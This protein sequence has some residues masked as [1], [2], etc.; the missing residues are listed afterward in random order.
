M[1]ILAG[2]V[3]YN[4]D[5]ARLK[6]NLDAVLEQCKN[7]VIFDNGSKNNADVKKIIDKYN[8]RIDLIEKKDNLGIAEALKSIMQY[9]IDNSYSWVLTLDQDSVIMPN[10]VDKYLE[11]V[12]LD[13]VG[14]LTCNIIDRNF[15]INENRNSESQDVDF[16]ITSGCFMSVDA[17]KKTCGYDSAMFIDKVDFDICFSLRD[18]GFRILKVNFDGLLHEVGHG[19]EIRFLGIKKTV[20][21]HPAWRRYY[22]AR[23]AIYLSRKHKVSENRFV[24]LFRELGRLS[25]VVLYE[26]DKV[27]KVTKT[28]CGLID[29]FTM[30][31]PNEI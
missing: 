25:V 7:I 11:C 18:K 13:G 14:A 17:Y 26:K 16:C 31:V 12:N 1:K 30:Y 6:E 9:A 20:F 24:A 15:K 23:N 19:K 10:L 5:V 28:L 4:P 22:M 2:I 3:T 21:N 27:N 8:A 29:G